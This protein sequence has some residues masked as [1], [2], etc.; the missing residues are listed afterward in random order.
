[1]HLGYHDYDTNCTWTAVADVATCEIDAMA[2]QSSQLSGSHSSGCL[3][4][5]GTCG[6]KALPL[7]SGYHIVNG[8]LNNC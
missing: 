4:A 3:Q 7:P 1:M 6:R 2:C 8:L 5:I